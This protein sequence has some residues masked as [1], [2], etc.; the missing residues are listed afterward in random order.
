MNSLLSDMPSLRRAWQWKWVLPREYQEQARSWSGFGVL[1]REAR[2]SMHQL[3]NPLDDSS[4]SSSSSTQQAGPARTWDQG[5]SHGSIRRGEARIA[6]GSSVSNA[7]NSNSSNGGG[8]SS[9]GEASIT[10]GDIPVMLD[11]WSGSAS[12]ARAMQQLGIE[13]GDDARA[14]DSAIAGTAAT[15]GP[16]YGSEGTSGGAHTT[17]EATI[18]SISSSSTTTTISSISTSSGQEVNKEYNEF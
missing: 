14:D 11:E 2:Q 10:L 8:G 6:V 5:D 9:S 16:A 7:T 3:L 1:K 4:S 18:S 12:A 13:S 15:N 17:P